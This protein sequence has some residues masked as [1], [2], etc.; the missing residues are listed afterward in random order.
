M[1]VEWGVK[2]ERGA[3]K[4]GNGGKGKKGE[5]KVHC[6]EGNITWWKDE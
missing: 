3:S 2:R 6:R 1:E 4:S 5:N